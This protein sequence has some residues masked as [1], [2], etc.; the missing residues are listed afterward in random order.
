MS[1]ARWLL[2]LG[3]TAGLLDLLEQALGLLALDP[4]LDRLRRLVDQ[5]LRLLEAE[6]GR[7]ADD[8]DH[9]DLLVAGAGQHEIDRSCFL[10]TCSI[11]GRP[12]GGGCSGR[13]G[14]RGNTELLLERLDAL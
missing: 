7:R 6:P 8:L 9:A 13:D 1:V 3:G 11:A 4:L 10:L 2:Y 14:G 5:R 12:A